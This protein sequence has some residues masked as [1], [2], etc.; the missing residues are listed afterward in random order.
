LLCLIT[1]VTLVAIN[2]VLFCE[3]DA[4]LQ[5]FPRQEI[6]VGSRDGLQL[7][8]TANTQSRADY[9]GRLDNSSDI[10]KITYFS[11]GKSLNATCGWAIM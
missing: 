3:V 11:D 1:F 7:N 5:S 4:Q 2:I 8:G 6:T 9:K 10:E